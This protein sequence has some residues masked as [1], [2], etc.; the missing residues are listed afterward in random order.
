[1]RVYIS[2]ESAYA[3]SYQIQTSLDGNNFTNL[4]VNTDAKGG[5]QTIEKDAFISDASARYV[6]IKCNEPV[7]A[8]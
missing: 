6:R 8:S 5:K 3:K 4:Y 2:W 1:M 7:K